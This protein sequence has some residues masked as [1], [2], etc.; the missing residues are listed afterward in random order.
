[1]LTLASSLI[2]GYLSKV[3]LTL[4]PSAEVVLERYSKPR[5][6]LIR[7]VWVRERRGVEQRG[8]V[9]AVGGGGGEGGRWLAEVLP[10]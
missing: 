1:M 2:L 6:I 4:S 9:E 5:A 3:A 10:F 8:R 7:S